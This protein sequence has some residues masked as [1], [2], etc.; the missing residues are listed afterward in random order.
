LASSYPTELEGLLTSPELKGVLSAARA[1]V[2]ES[3]ALDLTA[4]LSTLSDNAALPWLKER[5]ALQAYQDRDD[6]EQVLQRGIA[7]LAKHNLER[8]LPRLG[9]EISKARRLGDDERAVELTKQRDEL[10]RSATKLLRRE[11]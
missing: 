1:T 3:G 2:Q 8:E 4:L 7:M 6:A 9:Q 5:L 11:R 10:G